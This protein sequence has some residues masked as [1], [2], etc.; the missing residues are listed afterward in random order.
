L[1]LY[2]R[3]QM[4][5]LDNTKPIHECSAITKLHNIKKGLILTPNL[6]RKLEKFEILPHPFGHKRV[7]EI[8]SLATRDTQPELKFKKIEVENL[9]DLKENMRKNSL[10]YEKIYFGKSNWHD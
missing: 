1:F 6:S 9:P 5:K 3:N 4:R 2:D 8:K 7:N 10:I